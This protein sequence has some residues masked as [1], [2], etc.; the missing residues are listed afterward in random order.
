MG[1]SI[2]LIHF[3]DRRR[4]RRALSDSDHGRRGQLGPAGPENLTGHS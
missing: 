2:G 4:A 1:A 3:C